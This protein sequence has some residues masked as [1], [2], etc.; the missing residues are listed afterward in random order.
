MKPTNNIYFWGKYI[1]CCVNILLMVPVLSFDIDSNSCLLCWSLRKGRNTS[2]MVNYFDRTSVTTFMFNIF[3]CVYQYLLQFFP[4][5]W[6]CLYCVIID[7][8][9][10]QDPIPG[11]GTDS[12]PLAALGPV[13][14]LTQ[15]ICQVLEYMFQHVLFWVIWTNPNPTHQK[16]YFDIWRGT[17]N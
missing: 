15:N 1:W 8:A 11:S 13:L 17:L 16:G 14:K 12:D 3:S 2:N 5:P 7:S 10:L 9:K 4:K 6:K